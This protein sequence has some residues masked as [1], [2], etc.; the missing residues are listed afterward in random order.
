MPAINVREYNVQLTIIENLNAL[1][2][3]FA[4][5]MP[6]CDPL[7]VN[8]IK[9][10]ESYIATLGQNDDEVLKTLIS[11]THDENQGLMDN[12]TKISEHIIEFLNNGFYEKPPQ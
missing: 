11:M 2:K 4:E 8:S 12:V 10:F 6:R 5:I 9:N 7:M 1:K 3:L